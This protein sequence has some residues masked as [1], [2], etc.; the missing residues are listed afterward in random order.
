MRI[1]SGK[2]RG[3]QI[4]APESLPVRPTTDRA[5]ES[6]FNWL[7]FR[8]DFEGIYVLDLF[9]GTGNISYEFISRGAEK[10]VAVD[11]NI[12]CTRFIKRTFDLLKASG[13]EVLQQE[14]RLA[15]H[16][17]HLKFDVVFADPPY[18]YLDHETIIRNVFEKGILK[19]EA[20]LIMEHPS[21]FDGS[22]LPG[23]VETRHYGKV[24]FSYFQN[25]SE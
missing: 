10:V 9:A 23:F 5:K 14:A 25:I 8:I 1:I 6:L 19:E 17:M 16:R 3:K 15:I 7:N 2:W 11:E 24:Y 13:S 20:W 21:T 22:E 4:Q 18:D 12:A